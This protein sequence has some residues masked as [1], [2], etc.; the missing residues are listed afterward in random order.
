MRD[1][2]RPGRRRWIFEEEHQRRRCVEHPE[3]FDVL[4]SFPEKVDATIMDAGRPLPGT[5]H[6]GDG[7]LSGSVTEAIA[8]RRCGS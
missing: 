3:S 8:L 5:G 1:G 4:A 6:R 2:D 7:D